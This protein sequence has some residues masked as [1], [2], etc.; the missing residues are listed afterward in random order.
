MIKR[1]LILGLLSDRLIRADENQ[2]RV[3]RTQIR[4]TSTVCFT[5][6]KFF[7]AVQTRSKA[8]EIM[9]KVKQPTRRLHGHRLSLILARAISWYLEIN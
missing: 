9:G 4:P 5:F 8:S 1:Q 7:S 3:F 2:F 6:Y